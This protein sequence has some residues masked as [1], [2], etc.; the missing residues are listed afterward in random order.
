MKR[1]LAVAKSRGKKLGTQNKKVAG[2]GAAARHQQLQLESM[3]LKSEIQKLYNSG[4]GAKL[5][6]KSLNNDTAA[7]RINNNKMF[8]L[9]KVQR[10]V[11]CLVKAKEIKARKR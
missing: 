7:L 8:H 10:I 5:I 6:Q 9:S 4:S 11:A 2:K 1:A 3:K